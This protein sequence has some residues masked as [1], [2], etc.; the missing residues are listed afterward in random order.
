MEEELSRLESLQELEQRHGRE[1]VARLRARE[2]ELVEL[3][4]RMG[5]LLQG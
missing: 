3:H 2:A 1:L 5:A 4:A